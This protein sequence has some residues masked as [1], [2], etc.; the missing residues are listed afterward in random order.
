[1]FQ[2]ILNK[3]R[4]E[5]VAFWSGIVSALLVVLSFVGVNAD[6]IA[7]VGTVATLVGIPVVRAKVSPVT[8]AS[9][10]DEGHGQ[11]GE[12]LYLAVGLFDFLVILRIFHLI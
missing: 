1:M 12:I 11:V 5:P 2:V 3:I 4:R 10:P 8:P 6:I 7:L 9:R